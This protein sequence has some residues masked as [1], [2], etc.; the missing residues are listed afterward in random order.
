MIEFSAFGQTHHSDR[1]EIIFYN[2]IIRC[3]KLMAS[4]LK[5]DVLWSFLTVSKTK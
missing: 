1:T 5:L 2:Q 4:E 3:P